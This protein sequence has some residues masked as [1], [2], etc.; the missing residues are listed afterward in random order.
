M[1]KLGYA[2]LHSLMW[3]SLAASPLALRNMSRMKRFHRKLQT[4]LSG[5]PC[6]AGRLNVR[7]QSKRSLMSWAAEMGQGF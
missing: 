3:G 4:L 7:L 2:G 5:L 1:T 6:R